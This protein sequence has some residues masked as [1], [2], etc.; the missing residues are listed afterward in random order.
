M[1]TRISS[2]KTGL[3]SIVGLFGGCGGCLLAV[4]IF[5]MTVGAMCFD[6]FLWCFFHEDVAWYVD[7]LAGLFLG[8]F[9]IPLAIVC[10]VAT[11]CDAVTPFWDEINRVITGG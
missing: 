10:F 7:V 5:N 3:A 6:Y 2:S 11:S 1:K 8:E 4:I 9:T